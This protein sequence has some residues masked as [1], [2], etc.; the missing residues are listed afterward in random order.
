MKK[1]ITKTILAILLSGIL[2]LSLAGCA[3]TQ[4]ATDDEEFKKS[5]N[6]W[7]GVH[8]KQLILQSG[9]PSTV[10][11][12][13]D[14]G[15]ILVYED[16]RRVFVYGAYLTVVHKKMFYV[17]DKGIIYNWRYERSGRQGF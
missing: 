17:N 15:E 12:D 6:S 1:K 8:K 10:A 11:S 4:K 5:M 7:I 16:L 3:S 14:K 13:G 2:C 9:P